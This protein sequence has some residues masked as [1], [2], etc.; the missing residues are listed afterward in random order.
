[1][2]AIKKPLG[3]LRMNPKTCLNLIFILLVLP[4]IATATT[5]I[6]IN[7]TSFQWI[8]VNLSSATNLT[9]GMAISDGGNYTLRG[10][11]SYFIL[12]LP[13]IFN[14][15]ER[16]IVNISVNTNGLIELLESGENCIECSDFGTHLSGDHISS[17]DAIFASNGDWRTDAPDGSEYLGVFNLGDKVVI[18]WNASTWEDAGK[19]NPPPPS[20]FQVILFSNGTVFWNFK[21]MNWNTH[22]SFTAD[23]FTGAYANEEDV[24]YVAGY[25]IGK[26]TFD[27]M[28]FSYN[29]WQDTTPPSV[30]LNNMDGNYTNDLTPTFSAT[31]TDVFSPLQKA[32]LYINNTAYGDN[33]SSISTGNPFSINA[34]SSLT[35]DYWEWTINCTDTEGNEGTSLERN[36]TIETTPPI[37]THDAPEGWQT[38]PFNVSLSCAD[39]TSGCATIYY[40]LDSL[41]WMEGNIIPINAEGNHTIEYYSTDNAGNTETTETVHAALDTTPPSLSIISPQNTTY[42]SVNVTLEFI[43][44]DSVSGIDTTFYNLD[45][46]GENISSGDTTLENLPNGNHNVTVFANNTAGLLTQKQVAFTVD[47]II[48]SILFANPTPLADDYISTNWIY[49]NVTATSNISPMD[50]GT[51]VFNGTNFTMNRV[52]SGINVSYWYNVTDKSEGE[53][54]YYVFANTSAPNTGYSEDRTVT[55]DTT[56]PITNDT[57]PEGWPNSP[58]IVNLDCADSYSGCATTVY[59]INSGNWT[60]GNSIP[61]TNDG[62]H[63]IGRCTW[64]VANLLIQC[65][66]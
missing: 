26:G 16:N 42:I 47:P 27:P 29:F 58:F 45:G 65:Y 51:L 43:V 28:S 41:I 15:L 54:I 2:K 14:F 52:G 23:M 1:M 62:N 24:E 31:C 21:E 53:Y 36:F 17:F 20:G 5:N 4:S 22:D 49:I 66:T 13:F 50:L 10:D 6:T 59:R 57:A 48:P 63:T 30:T 46:S 33:S 7:E 38:T 34:N 44:S 25:E 55:V 3:H 32:T 61:I 18:E 12:S 8:D 9:N 40:R 56:P 64:W 60:S 37:T 11:D 35:E 19:Q 39:D